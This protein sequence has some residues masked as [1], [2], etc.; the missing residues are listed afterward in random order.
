MS[1]HKGKEKAVT[2]PDGLGKRSKGCYMKQDYLR[3]RLRGNRDFYPS[4]I[5]NYPAQT[6]IAEQSS[7]LWTK[8][9]ATDDH[10]RKPTV[11]SH[12]LLF[13]L[14]EAI[15]CGSKSGDDT[16]FL[17]VERIGGQHTR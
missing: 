1:T 5:I 7:D 4:R 10:D 2:D 12:T 15:L 3:K 8:C 13:H 11:L 14:L 6:I 17:G 16:L 9:W